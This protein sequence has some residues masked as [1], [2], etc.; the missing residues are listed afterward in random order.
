MAAPHRFELVRYYQHVPYCIDTGEDGRR[1]LYFLKLWDPL[2]E[3]PVEQARV[4]AQTTVF[5]MNLR[6]LGSGVFYLQCTIMYLFVWALYSFLEL[7][8]GV[9]V[10]GDG[11]TD[12]SIY[13]GSNP[14]S[15]GKTT[16]RVSWQLVPFT[17]TLFVFAAVLY[18][19][20]SKILRYGEAA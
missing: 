5:P 6:F 12:G 7:K 11:D 13:T 17:A 8:M 18:R 9:D 16:V 4:L 14:N 15:D 1:T 20:V 10:D 19:P 3:H 2:P